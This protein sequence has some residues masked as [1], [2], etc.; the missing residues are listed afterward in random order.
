MKSIYNNN[1]NIIILFIYLWWRNII[2]EVGNAKLHDFRMC[3]MH[4]I[5]II[6]III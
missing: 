5:I 2:N 6:I 3:V 1:N 4:R